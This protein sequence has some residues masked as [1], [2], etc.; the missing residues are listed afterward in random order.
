MGGCA[1]KPKETD[2]A[3]PVEAPANPVK[4]DAETVPQVI[5]EAHRP[6]EAVTHRL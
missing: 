6:R 4:G 1:S 3:V 5:F 2:G